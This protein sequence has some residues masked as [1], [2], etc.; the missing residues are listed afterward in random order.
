MFFFCFKCDN[1]FCIRSD[2]STLNLLYILIFHSKSV[3]FE[4]VKT[5]TKRFQ[6][7]SKPISSPTLTIPASRRYETDVYPLISH[8]DHPGCL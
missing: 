6:S 7:L 3:V 8:L 2:G 5:K 1:Q 4:E